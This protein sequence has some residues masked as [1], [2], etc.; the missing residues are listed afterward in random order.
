ME[1]ELK[2]LVLEDIRYDYE[3]IAHELQKLEQKNILKLVTSEKDFKKELKN[4]DPDIILSDYNLPEYDGMS[5]LLYT[6]KAA[7]NTPFIIVTGSINEEIAVDCIKAGASDY[8]T[9]EHLSRLVYAINGALKQKAIIKE[10]ERTQK[11]LIES[12]ELYRRLFEES[13]DP[14]LI[15]QNYKFIDCNH[16]TIDFLGYPDKSGIINHEPGDLSPSH[17]PDGSDSKEKAK[18]MINTALDKGY[19]RF[20]WVHKTID[21]KEIWVDISLTHIPSIDKNAIYA[22]WRNITEQKR[23]ELTREVLYNISEFAE[24]AVNLEDLSKKIH[25]EL[26]KIIDNNNFYI[27]LYHSKK[28]TYTFPFFKDKYD[29]IT[30]EFEEKLPNTITDYVRRKGKAIRITKE[31]E[32]KLNQSHEIISIGEYSPVWIGAPL[33]DTA[34]EEVIGVVAIQ[35]YED[36]N[37][38]TDED[39]NLLAFVARNIG[40]SLA[41]KKAEIHIL[42][43]EEKF[44]TLFDSAID[45]I[46]ILENNKILECNKA[47]L[48]MF[49][50]EKKED[51]IGK[52]P[53][54]ISPN[55][56]P[57][58][59]NSLEKAQSMINIAL[60]KNSHT[61]YWKHQRNDGNSFDSEI[62][63]NKYE[64]GS[65][66]YIQ[67]IIKDITKRKQD[68]EELKLAKEKA[69][70]S[71][72][73]KTAFLANMSHEI[74]TPMNAILGFSE[75]L[76]MADLSKEERDEFITLIQTNSNALLTLINDII[77]IAKI[78][79]GQ[80]KIAKKEFSVNKLLDDIHKT[81]IEIKSNQGK[82]HIELNLIPP[83]TDDEIII[84]SD[85]SRINQVI[86]NLVGN[87]IKY[88]EE[89]KI[90]FGFKIVNEN[91]QDYFTFYIKDTGI[92]IPPNKQQ[93]IFDRFRQGDDS[94]TREYG[95]TGLGLAISK[96]IAK[97]LKGD[98]TVES[99][100]DIGSVFYFKIP[101]KLS[102]KLKTEQK[103]KSTISDKLD[104]SG[105]TI[106]IAEDV[107]SNFQLLET[108]LLK[109]NAKI[110]WAQNGQEAIDFCKNNNDIDLI[111]MDMQMPVLN[112]YEATKEIK[113]FRPELPIIA[114]TAFA[115]AGDKEKIIEAGCD[116][117]VSKPIKAS[118][119][120]EI[121]KTHIK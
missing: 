45:S 54:E 118:L 42:E 3:L 44:R 97:L 49:G 22:I 39:V 70:E 89:G 91:K 2:I 34:N 51:I 31:I 10:K 56:Q 72:R 19:H 76:S 30:P 113:K 92:G 116:D 96:N 115:L 104:L 109:T 6:L 61:F 21:S 14:I 16:S 74:R 87:A 9:K 33:I 66:T 8:V 105:K 35:N 108:Y 28:D 24:K 100:E 65:R 119:L 85:Q 82:Q 40:T 57:D 94:H 55:I 106:L 7:P 95:G 11:K 102:T 107:E 48:K 18:K 77:D 75:L 81:Y 25:E 103:T 50:I 27:A 13:T 88:T 64:I 23:A 5:A 36:E 79:A 83:D 69:E 20:E 71:D 67:S 84:F 117:Y 101:I 43:S 17:Q 68:E 62:S 53:W 47:T 32:K 26:G 86:C 78:E 63:L 93:V 58:G 114:E 120:Y 4:F 37:A 38:L 73:L 98:I 46:F 80:L 110:L 60:K 59:N 121:I 1:K 99:E 111:L 90:E 52:T 12:E 112:G 41:R 29:N 15:I